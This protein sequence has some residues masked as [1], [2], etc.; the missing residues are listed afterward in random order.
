MRS[1]GGILLARISVRSSIF[2][3]SRLSSWTEVSLACRFRGCTPSG[4][5]K[6]SRDHLLV[7]IR[8]AQPFGCCN[9]AT[10]QSV[11]AQPRPRLPLSDRLQQ[12]HGR[13]GA[14]EL[15]LPRSAG[16]AETLLSR[17][18]GTAS[19]ATLGTSPSAAAWMAGEGRSSEVHSGEHGVAV[20]QPLVGRNA[21]VQPEVHGLRQRRKRRVLACLRAGSASGIKVRVRV[22]VGVRVS[23][24]AKLV[25]R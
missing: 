15:Q 11:R 23:V 17:L 24:W 9:A 3:S 8:Y 13:H 19:D 12:L 18:A 14:S 16:G 1:H 10:P 20:L 5:G 4:A 22:K 2:V 6:V 7:T 21:L 25:P